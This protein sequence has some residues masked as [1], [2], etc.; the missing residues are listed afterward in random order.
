M[1]SGPQQW[2]DKPEGNEEGPWDSKPLFTS[3]THSN[4]APGPSPFVST[5]FPPHWSTT[6]SI[7]AELLCCN[8]PTQFYSGHYF[9]RSDPNSLNSHFS[10]GPCT[11]AFLLYVT[12]WGRSPRSSP[13]IKNYSFSSLAT[14]GSRRL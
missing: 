10:A 13:H 6:L 4:K 11:M 8:F 2:S 5:S 12:A 1:T 9:V 3:L 7:P 14:E